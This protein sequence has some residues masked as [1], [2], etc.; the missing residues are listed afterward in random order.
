[1][2]AG[3]VRPYAVGARHLA[4]PVQTKWEPVETTMY[5][6]RIRHDA[7]TVTIRTAASSPEAAT[8][9]VLKAESAPA[10]SVVSVREAV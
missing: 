10:R 3:D 4:R 9:I 6:V 1:M 7:G 8:A 2:A 5:D